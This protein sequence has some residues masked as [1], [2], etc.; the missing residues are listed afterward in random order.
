MGKDK[1]IRLNSYFYVSINEREDRQR[2]ENI[3]KMCRDI[4]MFLGLWFE[5]FLLLEAHDFAIMIYNPND[6]I[7]IRYIKVCFLLSL[8]L[9][10]LWNHLFTSVY[11]T[12]FIN[13][14]FAYVLLFKNIKINKYGGKIYCLGN[15]NTYKKRVKIIYLLLLILSISILIFNSYFVKFSMLNLNILFFDI[16]F[17][18]NKKYALFIIDRLFG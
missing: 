10:V 2:I 4:C 14:V 6:L 12:R 9:L 11:F 13:F 17:M 1:F 16:L 5:I 3:I 7:N 15:P 8:L 18:I